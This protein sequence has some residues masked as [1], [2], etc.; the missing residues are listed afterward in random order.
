MITKIIS[1]K[2]QSSCNQT[3]YKNRALAPSLCTKTDTY[4]FTGS[5]GK[6]LPVIDAFKQVLDLVAGKNF[7]TAKKAFYLPDNPEIMLQELN[8][9]AEKVDGSKIS[10][11]FT[12]NNPEMHGQSQIA[13]G[14]LEELSKAANNGQIMGKF[15]DE[16]E[17]ASKKVKLN[18]RFTN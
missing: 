16:L 12:Y 9:H 7:E 18:R 4:T 17:I 14:T 11:F 1:Y 8:L 5:P 13:S 3:S 15:W 10:L 6:C 2:P